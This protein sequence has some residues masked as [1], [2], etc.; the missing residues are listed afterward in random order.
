ML[1]PI[2]YLKQASKQVW[3]PFYIHTVLAFTA[4]LHHP[5]GAVFLG[6]SGSRANSLFRAT[7]LE[8]MPSALFC[9]HCM[10]LY[11]KS[12]TAIPPSVYT[13]S[14]CHPQIGMCCSAFSWITFL[15]T[16]RVAVGFKLLRFLMAPIQRF[17]MTARNLFMSLGSSCTPTKSHLLHFGAHWD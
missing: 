15:H 14:V 16:T 8:K 17:L 3:H 10:E 2:K 9:C 5:H 13:C 4:L 1:D 6:P 7:S 11:R 12:C